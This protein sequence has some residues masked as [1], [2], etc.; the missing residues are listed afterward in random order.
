M[1]LLSQ[2]IL[3]SLEGHG[4]TSQQTTGNHI[5]NNHL[6]CSQDLSQEL[7]NL[8]RENPANPIFAYINISSKRNDCMKTKSTHLLQ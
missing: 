1:Q 6:S 5:R 7:K 3:R 8:R 2:N 4:N